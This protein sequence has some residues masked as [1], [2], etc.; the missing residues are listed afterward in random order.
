M[1]D[2]RIRNNIPNDPEYRCKY[3]KYYMQ[4]FDIAENIEQNTFSLLQVNQSLYDYCCN[5]LIKN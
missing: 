2:D 4:W 3:I 1:G 5:Y